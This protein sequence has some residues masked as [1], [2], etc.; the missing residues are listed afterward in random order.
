MSAGRA[1]F[2]WRTAG[3]AL[4]MMGVCVAAVDARGPELAR[5]RPNIVL[6]L[7][8]DMGF[9]DLG[10]YG[11]EI[12]TPHIDALAKSGMRF[13][14]FYNGAR[15]CPTRA[16]LLTG[17]YA[18]QT[19][20]GHMVGDEGSPAYRG[21]L[22]EQCVTIAE[23]LRGAGY[24]T[25]MSGKWHVGQERPHWP[26]DRGFEHYFG[27][28]SGAC[29]YFTLEP[30]RV[31]ARDNEL[32]T[33]P[34]EGFYMTDAFADSA[35]DFVRQCGRE[36]QPFFLYLAFTAPHWPLQAWPSDI[37][38]YR[39]HWMEGWDVLR[40]RRY[41]RMIDMGLIDAR[42]TLSA[43]TPEA[44]A[45]EEVEDKELRD[46]RMAVYAAQIDRMDQGVGRVLAALDAA[47]TRDD[48][49]VL[50]LSDNG[51][52]AETPRQTKNDVAPGPRDSFMAYGR[53]WAMLSNTPF[54]FFKSYT[55]EGGI[56]TPLIASWPD[57][58][59]A[60]GLSP[61][62]GHVI[63]I[64][65]TVLDAAGATYP[66]SINGRSITRLEGLSLLPVLRGGKRAGHPALF[67]EHEGHRAVRQG[68]WKLVS[69][70]SAAWELYDLSADRTETN[71]LAA[72]RA[73]KVKELAALYDAWAKR[74]GVVP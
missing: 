54:R 70:E 7:A 57:V 14:E 8:D 35:V 16:A 18:H 6:I 62:V 28:I 34:R 43:R 38:K 21:F 50:F 52:S 49:L 48:T 37:A 11:S 40:Q 4:V 19:G 23:V 73:D 69:L 17:L 44:H 36:Q 26:L 61:E 51:A 20:V 25:F 31:M 64:M 74:C 9:S 59:A 66:E 27:L 63:D 12:D 55:H 42:W 33:P 15:C 60:G 56:A 67:W 68:E 47:G 24:R 32:Y 30:E 46:L 45:W 10:C 58:V 3:T 13:T 71:D 39:G 41:R 29:N 65:A 72:R 5:R 22:N 1:R 53:P 2:L